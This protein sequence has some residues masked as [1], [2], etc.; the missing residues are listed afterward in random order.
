MKIKINDRSREVDRREY[1]RDVVTAKHT[2]F[3][4]FHALVTAPGG[5]RPSI[6]LGGKAP[7]D[8][9]ELLF[10][11]FAYNEYQKN[12]GDH[13]RVYKG[14]WHPVFRKEH[15]LLSDNVLCH[16]CDEPA[17]G[18]ALASINGHPKQQHP[19]CQCHLDAAREDCDHKFVD[20]KVCLKCGWSP[21]TSVIEV[22]AV[23]TPGPT[24]YAGA[25]QQLKESSHA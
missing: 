9:R 24:T 20:S 12:V 18:S 11:T 4:N 1:D 21:S 16:V 14:D 5:Y 19:L 6:Y 2:A 22:T 23:V 17:V 25:I 3:P 13:R 8:Q 15:P 10:L 7:K